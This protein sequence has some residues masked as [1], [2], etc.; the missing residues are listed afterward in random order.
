MSININTC[1]F[2]F[3]LVL[4]KIGYLYR[5]EI[6]LCLIRLRVTITTL[7][8]CMIFISKLNAL[9]T[10]YTRIYSKRRAFEILNFFVTLKCTEYFYFIFLS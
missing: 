2:L 1:S 8:A 4:I 5:V 9:Y 6:L 7:S 10:Y 3:F